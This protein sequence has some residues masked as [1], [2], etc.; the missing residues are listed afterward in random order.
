MP[1]SHS[2]IKTRHNLILAKAMNLVKQEDNQMNGFAA[3]KFFYQDKQTGL[4]RAQELG[5]NW[6]EAEEFLLTDQNRKIS[7]SLDDAIQAIGKNAVSKADKQALYQRL[8]N[9]RSHLESV[10]PGGKDNPEFQKVEAAIVDYIK[11]H[12][13]FISVNG[14]ATAVPGIAPI[15]PVG[16]S[17]IHAN[18]P[19]TGNTDNLEKFAKLVETCYR[20]GAPSKTELELLEKFRQKY[21]ISPEQADELIAKALG[22]TNSQDAVQEFGLMYRAFLE[23]DGEIDL[24]E[25]SQLLNLQDELGLTNEQVATIEANVRTELAMN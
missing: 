17:T 15:T 22:T 24:D 14:S 21:G 2:E 5:A 20:R 11:T 12:G 7:D 4:D 25:Q 13:L 8:M 6:D 1:S 18:R 16:I 23:N 3:I 19:N 10:T 9:Y